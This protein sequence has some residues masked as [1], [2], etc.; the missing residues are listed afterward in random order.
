M[1]VKVLETTNHDKSR[2]VQLPPPLEMGD[3]LTRA[4]FERRYTNMPP[5][6][7]A[8]LIEG[9]VFISATGR[10]SHGRPHA[11]ILGW[12]GLYAAQTPMIE[13]A[14]N[15]TVCL[16]ADNEVQPDVLLRIVEDAGSQSTISTDDYVEGAS[17]LIVEIAASSVSYDLYD[18]LPVYRR[19]GVQ[20]YLVWQVYDQK[21][22]WF[23][24]E[25]GRYVPLLLNADGIIHSRN[26]PGLA[27]TV[28]PLLQGD[29]ATVLTILSKNNECGCT[30]TVCFQTNYAVTQ[31]P[32]YLCR[33]N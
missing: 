24:L 33:K 3:R 9:V 21:I 4:E 16:D 5:N 15:A 7:K 20:E 22:D 26:F 19:N 27:L 1:N 18:K 25:E 10:Y 29:M 31:T 17:E 6:K 23:V 13:Y 28:D 32:S 8:E 30:Q 12:L 2:Q 14:D 11:Y